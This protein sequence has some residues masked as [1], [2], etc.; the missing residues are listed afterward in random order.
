MNIKVENMLKAKMISG[1]KSRK[2]CKTGVILVTT[3]FIVVLQWCHVLLLL[4]LYLLLVEEQYINNHVLFL[5]CA[6]SGYIFVNPS[7]SCV[8]DC[9]QNKQCIIIETKSETNL[10]ICIRSL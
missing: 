4:L 10:K 8:T 6:L 2:S 5:A 9:Y 7:T 1:N 3:T